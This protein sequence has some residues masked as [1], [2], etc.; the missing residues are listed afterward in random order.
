[1]HR[2]PFTSIVAVVIGVLG[3]LTAAA[4]LFLHSSNHPMPLPPLPTLT[5]VPTVAPAVTGT[6]QPTATQVPNPTSLL[7]PTQPPSPN[8]TQPPNP[9]P[10]QPAGGQVLTT[11]GFSIDVL[12][13]WS[14]SQ[15]Q[16]NSALLA[17]A[18]GSG[19]NGLLYVGA[20]QSSSPTTAQTILQNTLTTLQQQY[21]DAKQCGDLAQFAVANI[22]GTAMPVCFTLTP[23]GGASFQALSVN[24]AATNSAGTTI[25]TLQE[26]GAE[27]PPDFFNNDVPPIVKTV[28]WTV[29]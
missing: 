1:M 3:I 9:S 13:G 28:N 5:V 10:T 24:W 7:N 17:H 6:Q 18:S 15:Q 14:V 16:S 29:S 20:G 21:P 8:P 2:L 22:P 27:N 26:M 4:V 25:Y 11:Q 12:S 23:Q 19:T